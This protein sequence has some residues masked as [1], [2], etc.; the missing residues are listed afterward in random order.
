[1]VFRRR[2]RWVL[3][4]VSLTSRAWEYPLDLFFLTLVDPVMVPEEIR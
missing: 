3:F 1:M 4:N 2:G